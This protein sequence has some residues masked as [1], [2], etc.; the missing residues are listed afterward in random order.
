MPIHQNWRTPEPLLRSWWNLAGRCPLPLSRCHRKEKVL[1]PRI[2]EKWFFENL[3]HNSTPIWVTN[4]GVTLLI[5]K[6]GGHHFYKKDA[7][8]SPWLIAVETWTLPCPW[9]KFFSWRL[10]VGQR[11]VVK[12]VRPRRFFLSHPP[13]YGPIL[14]FKPYLGSPALAAVPQIEST[15]I[16]QKINVLVPNLSW[17]LAIFWW[18]L[19]KS[20]M[21][22][23][24][25]SLFL[26]LKLCPLDHRSPLH[27]RSLPYNRFWP[28]SLYVTGKNLFVISLGHFSM[29]ETSYLTFPIKPNG[30]QGTF[31]K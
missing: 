25:E 8:D 26:A 1:R 24:L 7:P 17:D 3:A 19:L 2:T 6:I 27:A 21:F 30:Q 22:S 10:L 14:N 12:N 23:L 11:W 9:K 15:S 13:I 18:N 28:G 29:K 5:F 4:Q 20:K 31:S 16:S